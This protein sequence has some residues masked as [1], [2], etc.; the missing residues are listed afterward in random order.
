M[1]AAKAGARYVKPGT[2]EQI[3]A[4]VL[5]AIDRG[6]PWV[7]PREAKALQLLQRFTPR[8]MDRATR[9]MLK[10]P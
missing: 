8:M 2:P 5:Q 10:G 1:P 3:V 9:L 4:S 6:K 7:F